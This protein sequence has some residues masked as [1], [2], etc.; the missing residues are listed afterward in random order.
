MCQN[1]DIGLDSLYCGKWRK[2]SKTHRDLDLDLTMSNSSEL[3]PHTTT[4]SRFKLT[5][6]L[7]FELTCTQT[8]RHKDRQ[9]ETQTDINT[10]RADTN[11]YHYIYLNLTLHEILALSVSVKV[12][13]YKEPT[14]H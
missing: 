5:H 4:C 11:D 9:T 7:Y 1:L 14:L 10:Y 13:K 3:F 12:L 2:I 6:P 8:N